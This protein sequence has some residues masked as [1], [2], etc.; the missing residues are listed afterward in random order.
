MIE[1]GEI[2]VPYSPA[3][4]LIS[5]DCVLLPSKPEEY[6]LKTEL[7]A[8][9][10]SFIHRYVDLTPLFEEIAASYVL[11]SWVY[12]RFNEV[13]YLRFRGDYGTGKTRALMAIGSLCYKPFFSSAASTTSPIFHT[14]NA[15]GGTLILDEADLPFSD[16]RAEL[17]KILNNGNVR[18]MPVLRSMQ[19]RTKEFCPTA[20]K[21][22]GPKIIAMRESF[23]DRALESRFFTEETGTRPMRADIPI[24]LPSTLKAEA[25]LLRNRLLHYRLC[26]Y[27]KINTDTTASIAGIEPRLNQSAL[28]LLS[29]IDDPALRARIQEDMIARNGEIVASRSETT[30]AH[31]ASAAVAASAESS[32][33]SASLQAIAETLRAQHSD[34]YGRVTSKWIG[35]ILRTRLHIKTHKSRGIY[36]V[37]FGEL[38]KLKEFLQ[39]AGVDS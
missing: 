10:Q 19:T 24:H 23:E 38:Q 14:L 34:E 35:Y 1:T 29:I 12:D 11:M 7:L 33:G 28:S 6:G 39:R 22:F 36:V 25:L 2:L 31:V 16:A 26:E 3:N 17:V 8:D 37:H 20:F 27:Y 4:N 21:V 9:I 13:P 32:D 15:F 30:E 5:N 18:G